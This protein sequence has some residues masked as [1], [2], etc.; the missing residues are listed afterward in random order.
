VI[1]LALASFAAFFVTINPIEA[2]AMFPVLTEGMSRPHQRQ[3]AA[4]STLV[5]GGLL[6]VFAL[7]GDDVLRVVG[8]SLASVRVGGG[9]LLMLVSID[10]VFGRVIGATAAAGEQSRPADI[11]VFPLAT[12]IIAGPG[13]ITAVVVKSSEV[14]N[15]VRLTGLIAGV[16]LVVMLLTFVAMLLAPAIRDALGETGMSVVIRVIGL[17]LTALSAELILKGLKDSGVFHSKTRRGASPPFRTSPQ[18]SIA[19]AKPA[20]EHTFM[21]NFDDTLREDA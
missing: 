11:S 3:I 2:A 13:A 20:L 12:P 16:L 9:V 10:I 21:A 8:I 18:E 15:D 14:D 19:P 6:L 17:L 4:K 7:L 1:E 5:A